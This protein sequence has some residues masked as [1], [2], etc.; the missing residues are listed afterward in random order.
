MMRLDLA[1]DGTEFRGYAIQPD[2][3][4]VQGELERALGTIYQSPMPTAAAGRT[5]AGVHARHQVVSYDDAGH[6]QPR[7][8]LG[9]LNSMLPEDIVVTEAAPAP[10]DFHARFSAK[11][12]SYR[13]RI[14][15]ARYRDPMRLRTHWHVDQRLDEAA[16]NAAMAH[17]IGQHD[18]TSLC[19]KDG[20]KGRERTVID[21]EWHRTDDLVELSVTA[22]AFCYQMVRSIAGLAVQVGL[23]NADPD[24]VPGII[25]AQDRSLSSGVAPPHGLTLWAVEY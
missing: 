20:D 16:M 22:V 5:D 17:L 14:W 9:R 19:R 24:S 1:Y 2:V 7:R 3:R 23:G 12:R 8:L 4:S 18:F 25:V 6:A 13:Y 21:C 15:N 11:S 10:D